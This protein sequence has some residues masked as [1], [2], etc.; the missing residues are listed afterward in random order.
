[1][2]ALIEY[3]F[4]DKFNYASTKQKLVGFLKCLQCNV[5]CNLYIVL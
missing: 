5:I 3:Y 1:M 2:V 4:T